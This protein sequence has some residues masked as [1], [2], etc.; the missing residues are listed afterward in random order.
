M[1]VC[2]VCPERV[3]CE[4]TSHHLIL[5]GNHMPIWRHGAIDSFSNGSKLVWVRVATE[6][7]RF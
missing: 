2:S 7:R 1:L 3:R 5:E 6:I 4:G